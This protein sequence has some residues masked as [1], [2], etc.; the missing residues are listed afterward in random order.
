MKMYPES[1]RPKWSFVKSIPGCR[2]VV[3]V[4]A[5]PS[6]YAFRILPALAQA[7]VLVL[8]PI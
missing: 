7:L 1:F 3:P 5:E 8:E 6:G 2:K 4:F